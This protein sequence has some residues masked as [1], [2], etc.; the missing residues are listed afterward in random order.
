MKE[1]QKTLGSKVLVLLSKMSLADDLSKL[2]PH[3]GLDKQICL[4]FLL[5]LNQWLR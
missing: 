4:N 5:L 2:L 3:F 1:T